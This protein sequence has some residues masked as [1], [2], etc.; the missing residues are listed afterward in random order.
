ME[1]HGYVGIQWVWT[2]AQVLPLDNLVDGQRVGRWVMGWIWTSST[3]P[4][5]DPLPSLVNKDA[6]YFRVVRNPV[7]EV[8][9]LDNNEPTSYGE[10]MVGSDSG[11]WLEA[12]K[13]E[14]IH[15]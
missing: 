2:W 13:S 4:K 5:P 14:R 15:V 6:Y 12:I 1:L 7:L 8:M 10:T 11:K 9:L 3:R